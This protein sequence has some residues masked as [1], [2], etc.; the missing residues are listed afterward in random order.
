MSVIMFVRVS[1]FRGQGW[2]RLNTIFVNLVGVALAVTL[3]IAAIQPANAAPKFAAIT[4]D[5]HTGRILFARNIDAPRYPASL[6]KIMTCSRILRPAA[7]N[8]IP[9]SEYPNSP[10]PVSRPNLA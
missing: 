7:S 1:E 9:S 4:L 10:P 8:S 6:T 5:A 2:A 3:S